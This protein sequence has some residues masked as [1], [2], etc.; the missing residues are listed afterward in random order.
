MVEG[1]AWGDLLAPYCVG[2]AVPC[3][4]CW[5]GLPLGAFLRWGQVGREGEELPLGDEEAC[6]G[7]EVIPPRGE[8]PA[9]QG[10]GLYRAGD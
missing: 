3:G 5:V 4:G 10:A 2:G 1:G 8:H 6:R 7:M 9:Y